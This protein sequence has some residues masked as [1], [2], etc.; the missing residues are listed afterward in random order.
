MAKFK[1][2]HLFA[3]VTFS[4]C[5]IALFQYSPNIGFLVLI[6]ILPTIPT[7]LVNKRLRKYFANA[8]LI[9]KWVLI[10]AACLSWLSIYVLSIGPV[11]AIIEYNNFDK[12]FA[13]PFYEPVIWLHDETLLEK[14][15]EWYSEIWG[16]H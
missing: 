2:W 14:P 15:L 13:R 16:W 9:K 4:A 11:V 8:S 3:L 7:L 6:S 5:L 1:L 12:D 10:T